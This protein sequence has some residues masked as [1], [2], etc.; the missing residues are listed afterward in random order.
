MSLHLETLRAYISAY[1]QTKRSERRTAPTAYI[2]NALLR[3]VI[4]SR[5]NAAA[6]LSLTTPRSL[7][8]IQRWNVSKNAHLLRCALILGRYLRAAFWLYHVYRV[9]QISLLS[10]CITREATQGARNRLKENI[11]LFHR[12][13]RSSSQTTTY[14]SIASLLEFD[15]PA[16]CSLSIALKSADQAVDALTSAKSD[17]NAGLVAGIDRMRVSFRV[18]YDSRYVTYRWN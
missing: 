1:L 3:S 18:I 8:T 9:I 12:V 5:P 15:H 10:Y 13:V 4:I 17:S 16:L 14:S 11:L 6:M 7:R 2:Y